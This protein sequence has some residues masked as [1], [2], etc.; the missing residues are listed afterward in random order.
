MSSNENQ[1]LLDFLEKLKNQWM[2]TIDALVDPLTIVSK[3]FEIVKANNAMAA[4]A[5]S[6]HVKEL[7]GNKCYKVF[8][9]S[10][11]PCPGCKLLETI[12]QSSEQ[13]FNLRSGS[14]FYEVTSQPIKDENGKTSSAVLVYR[15]RTQAKRLQEQ[16]FQSEK[17]ASIGLLAGGI[18]HEINN[19]L[20]GILIFTQMLLREVPKGSPYIEDLEEIEAATKR[21]KEIVMR[22]LEFA[23]QKPS[24]LAKE[25]LEPTSAKEAMTRALKFARVGK[26]AKECEVIMD[27]HDEDLM[28][29]G[30]QNKL[31][32]LFLNLMQNAFQAMEGSGNLKIR[33]EVDTSNTSDDDKEFTLI[34]IIDNGPGIPQKFM[35]RIFDPFFT[36]KDPGE[37]TGLG[38]AICYGIVTELH[39]QIEVES[40]EGEGTRFSISLPSAN[41]TRLHV[42]A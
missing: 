2:A 10:D 11:A 5:D 20:G 36:T 27:L 35:K 29:I 40:T 12:D 42:S 32:Q 7:L 16:L 25:D 19:P 22:L 30:D 41:T 15:D 18:A 38:L 4:H 34:H 14:N 17:L 6:K 28:V 39:G 21:C 37:G 23:R 9:K 31:V 8:A 33:S 26:N 3:D 24:E 13:S 1:E